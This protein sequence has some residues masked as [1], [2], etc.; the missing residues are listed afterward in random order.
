MS[1]VLDRLIEFDPDDPR[2]PSQQIAN[3][4]RAAILSGRLTSGERLPTQLQLAER[5]GVARETV[6]AALRILDREGLIVSRQG[7]GSFVRTRQS[8]P[9]DIRS[10]LRTALDRTDVSIDY[11][12][13]RGET[14]SHMLPGA[15]DVVRS[16][17]AAVRAL[18]IRLLLTDPAVDVALPQPVDPSQDATGLQESLAPLTE[19]AVARIKSSVEELTSTG[20]IHAATVA[21]RVHRMAPVMKMYTLNRE[22]TLIGFYPITEHSVTLHGRDLTLHH[23]SGWDSATFDRQADKGD[24]GSPSFAHQAQQWFETVWSTIAVDYTA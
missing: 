20:L 13:W 22:R 17:Q 7:S 6:K 19:R 8:V 5:Y 10:Y 1:S 9:T 14:L 18:R 12:G 21:V 15:L 24:D 23:P 4:L 16:G 3:A 11:A 2:T